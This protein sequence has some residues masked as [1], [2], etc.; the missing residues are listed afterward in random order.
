MVNYELTLTDVVYNSAF[1]FAANLKT[2]YF[3]S[4]ILF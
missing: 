2:I 4:S 3:D 1:L